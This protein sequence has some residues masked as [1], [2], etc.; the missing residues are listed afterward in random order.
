MNVL[1]HLL[2]SEPIRTR[3]YPLLVAIG[4]VL[5]TDGIVTQ[6]VESIVLSV[7]AALLSVGGVEAARRKVTPNHK[8]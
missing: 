2:D 4:A 6:S 5:V 3:L 1:K 8:L 7:V